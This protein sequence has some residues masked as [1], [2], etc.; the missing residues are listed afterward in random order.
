M[1]RTSVFGGKN[2]RTPET[3]RIIEQEGSKFVGKVFLYLFIALA[4]TAITCVLSGLLITYGAQG[5]SDTLFLIFEVISICSL[6]AYIPVIIWT[7]I[8]LLRGG[9]GLKPAFVIY[10]VLMGVFLSSLTAFLDFY[11]IA[12]AFGI[13]CGAFAVMALI[14]WTSKRNLNYL[15]ILA[16]GLLSGVCFVSIFSLIVGLFTGM[17]SGVLSA[18][19]SGG[20]F[21]FVILI[22]LVDLY[23]IKNIA[24]RGQASDNLAMLCAYNLYIDFIYIFLRVLIFIARFAKRR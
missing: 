11:I 9:K 18:M 17:Q 8:S 10:S 12:T 15:T 7:Q 5:N 20:I 4:I 13:T 24:G 23:N 3:D 22:T 16:Y 2:Y 14:A 21:I 6:V 1:E 19:V